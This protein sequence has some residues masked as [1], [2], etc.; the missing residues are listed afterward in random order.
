MKGLKLS[1]WL[2]GV[3]MGKQADI[4]ALF[5]LSKITRTQCFM[6]LSNNTYWST[7]KE[8]PDYHEEYIWVTLARGA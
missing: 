7:L 3:R 5:L 1:T 6:Y 8:E 4:L 2:N